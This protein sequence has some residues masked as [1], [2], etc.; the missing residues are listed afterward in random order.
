MSEVCVGQF[1][2]TLIAFTYSLFLDDGTS[3]IA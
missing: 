3:D 2:A 1:T